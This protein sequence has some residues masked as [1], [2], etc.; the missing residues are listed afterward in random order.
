MGL[1][2]G[3]GLS[4]GLALLSGFLLTKFLRRR[5]GEARVILDATKHED[6]EGFEDM[7]DK[8]LFVNDKI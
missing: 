8:S 1:G 4:L 6:I 3:V 5:M 2:L 7:K